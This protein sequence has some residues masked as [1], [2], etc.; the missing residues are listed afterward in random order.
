MFSRH[1]YLLLFSWLLF[2]PIFVSAQHVIENV[3]LLEA[4]NAQGT[5]QLEKARALFSAVLEDKTATSEEKC[6]ALRELAIQDWKFY[7]DYEGARKRLLMA[8]SIGVYRS[9]TWLKMHTI[10]ESAGYYTKAL[11]AAQKAHRLAIAESDKTL[12]QYRYCRTILKQAMYQMDTDTP[13]DNALLT[14]GTTILNAI[15]QAN[16]TH[17]NAAELLLGISLIQQD[18]SMALKSWLSYF[19][20]SDVDAVY[21]YLK[22]PATALN[23]VL[24]KWKNRSL[25]EVD[26]IELI[27]SLAASRF[28]KYAKIVALEF[29]NNANDTLK[30]TQAIKN[31]IAYANYLDDIKNQTDE[32]YRLSAIGKGNTRTYLAF[33]ASRNKTLYNTI[34]VDESNYDFERFKTLLKSE[35]GTVVF[36]GSTTSSPITGLVMGHIVNTQTRTIEQYGHTADFTFTEGERRPA[37]GAARGVLKGTASMGCP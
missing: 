16:P 34:K 26:K 29:S 35:F 23:T 30:D 28:Y 10:T 33:L 5:L 21:E 7:K 17:V 31:I 25:N 13:Y 6:K 8:D 14:E 22:E 9:E 12:A 18:G 4:F 20:F 19:R 1:I 15:L 24:P 36:I 3:K 11:E 37:P 2:A 27:K 32:Y